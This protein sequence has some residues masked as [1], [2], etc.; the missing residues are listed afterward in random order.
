M[1]N[2]RL[3]TTLLTLLALLTLA[4]RGSAAESASGVTLAN[5]SAETR[6][7]VTTHGSASPKARPKFERN[8]RVLVFFRTPLTRQELKVVRDRILAKVGRHG[9]RY[10]A[11]L[12]LVGASFYTVPAH[13][14]ESLAA[15]PDVQYV[16]V[17]PASSRA[18][19]SEPKPIGAKATKA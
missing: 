19:G 15:D 12:S 8:V 17:E 5:G 11:S 3:A 9:G 2:T 4:P 7:I 14:A 10:T 16:S 1:K 13:L 6:E 18:P